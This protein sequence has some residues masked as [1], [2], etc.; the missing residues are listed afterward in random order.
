MR[1]LQL[2]QE[3]N[4]EASLK[5]VYLIIQAINQ[6]NK[7]AKSNDMVNA[8]IKQADILKKTPDAGDEEGESDKRAEME[9]EVLN[10]YS[11]KLKKEMLERAVFLAVNLGDFQQACEY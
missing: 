6:I 4:F 9:S 10:C 7:A 11:L 3:Q 2:E 5:L 1:A 8:Q